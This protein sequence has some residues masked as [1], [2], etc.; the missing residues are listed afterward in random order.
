VTLEV[1]GWRV[2]D[3]GV[4]VLCLCDDEPDLVEGVEEC[5][6]VV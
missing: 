6:E 4:G 3:A 5:A 1:V 2:C